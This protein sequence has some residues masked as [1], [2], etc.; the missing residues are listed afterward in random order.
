MF[1]ESIGM[2][3]P[4]AQRFH[5]P[6]RE[7]LEILCD[8]NSGMAFDRRS[9]HMPILGIIGHFFDQW[10]V[11]FHPA[12]W[13]V[14]PERRFKTLNQSLFPYQVSGSAPFPR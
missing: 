9:R 7:M 5:I 1:K 2:Q 13:K 11:I 10:F 14:F 8:D 3:D 6:R 4:D 12:I